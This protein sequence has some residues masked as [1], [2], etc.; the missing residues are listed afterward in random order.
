MYHPSKLHNF[1]LPYSRGFMDVEMTSGEGGA[2]P[3]VS[4]FFLVM[5][6]SKRVVVKKTQNKTLV[7]MTS[8]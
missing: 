1:T 7:C 5:G 8:N 6:K 2:L 3:K 4:E